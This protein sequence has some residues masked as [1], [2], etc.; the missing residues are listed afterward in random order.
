MA[1]YGEQ[2]F[3]LNATSGEGEEFGDMS[4]MYKYRFKIM[5]APTQ[6]IKAI[7]TDKKEAF[8]GFSIKVACEGWGSASVALQCKTSLS[9]DSW[10][11]TGDIFD[12]DTA[13]FF[14]Y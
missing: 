1:T 11:N 12:E 3:V 6:P 8:N 5:G 13:R 2:R 4:G 7:F 10:S 14:P 9:G